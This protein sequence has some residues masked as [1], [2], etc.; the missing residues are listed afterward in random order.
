MA[1]PRGA[2][3]SPDGASPPGGLLPRALVMLLGAAAAVVVV[4]GV[5]IGAWL[6]APV[7]MALVIVIAVAPVQDRL[8]RRGRP[9][10]LTTVVLVLCVYGVL[11]GLALGIVVSL[12]RLAALLPQYTERGS[13]VVRS[14]TDA[15]A[16][17]G[18]GRDQLR[19]AIDG[20]DLGRLTEL[21]TGL[22]A[23]VAGLVS[24]LAFL[25]ALLLFLA[26]EAG[27]AGERIA[28]IAQDR[29]GAAEALSR[30][31]RGTRRYLWVTTV[32][33]LV[34]A[35]LDTVALAVIGVPLALTWGLLAFVTNYIPNIGFL[36]GLLPPALVALLGGGLGEMIAVVVC[37]GVLNF[38]LQSLIQPRFVGDAVGLSVTATFVAL[39]FWAWLLGPL[40]A[41]LAIPV[42]LLV[43]ALLVDLDPRARWADVLLSSRPSPR[44]AA[45]RSRFVFRR[46]RSPAG[47]RRA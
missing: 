46:V 6:I 5:R 27:G 40:G 36:I 2:Q 37:Y 44:P 21:L 9:A 32:F 42:T 23:D 10:W 25:L 14:A 17:V 20:L 7:L 1:D 43:K 3:T 29:P 45:T 16:A 41:I 19:A 26:V 12:A 4:T 28:A 15:L 31:T 24:N 47:E 11:V 38:V 33:G 30:F 18:I 39:V 13:D 8:H 34:V 35:A 22:L